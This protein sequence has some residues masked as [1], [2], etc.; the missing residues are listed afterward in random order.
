MPGLRTAESDLEGN[1][2]VLGRQA[3]EGES[4]VGET[5]REQAGS[6]VPRDTWNLVGSEGDH[7]L[8]LNTTQ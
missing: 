8:R 4:P 1:G 7:P 2:T 5:G 3:R 6:K